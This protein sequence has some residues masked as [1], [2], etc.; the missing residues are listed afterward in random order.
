MDTYRFRKQIHKLPG[1]EIHPEPTNDEIRKIS[2]TVTTGVHT[3][4]SQQG[5]SSGIGEEFSEEAIRDIVA[6]QR[7]Y[8]R[9]GATLPVGWCIKQLKKLKAAVIAHE[10][11]LEEALAEA[12]ALLLC[13]F[14]VVRYAPQLVRR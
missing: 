4:S 1:K 6:A 10:A 9:T 14:L 2:D 8:F 7:K 13:A 3:P 12:L 11:E 5:I